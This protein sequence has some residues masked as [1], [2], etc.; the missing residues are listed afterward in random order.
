MDKDNR[1]SEDQDLL[2]SLRIA[3]PCSVDWNSMTGDERK[4][5]CGLCKKNVYNISEMSR[6]DAAEFIRE[7]EGEATCIRF[8][9][10]KDG[11][12]ITDNCPLGLRKLRD[13]SRAVIVACASFL[14]WLTPQNANAQQQT[15]TSVDDGNSGSTSTTIRPGAYWGNRTRKPTQLVYPP[16]AMQGGLSATEVGEVAEVKPIF[17]SAACK[18]PPPNPEPGRFAVMAG[19]LLATALGA[20]AAW[21][22]KKASL[23]ILGSVVAL[24][25]VSAGLIWGL[26]GSVLSELMMGSSNASVN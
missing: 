22:R 23:W 17:T 24:I 18:V 16:E 19:T 15:G 11:T 10:R 2:N 6:K 14:A 26:S 8:Y 25:L 3:A 1:V 13:R 5:F 7:S 21:R 4:R 12:V 20:Y 9:R